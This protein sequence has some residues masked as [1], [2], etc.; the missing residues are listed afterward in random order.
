MAESYMEWL[1]EQLPNPDEIEAISGRPLSVVEGVTYEWGRVKIQL[2]IR[3][4]EERITPEVREAADRLQ[5]WR[6]G[7]SADAIYG[8]GRLITCDQTIMT[9]F[10]LAIIGPSN[11]DHAE[12]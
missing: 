2:I 9:D 7:E 10:A 4:L 6:R 12:S 1:A 11:V 8:D 3:E 5:R